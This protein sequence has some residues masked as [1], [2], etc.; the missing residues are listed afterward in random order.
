M[1]L[2][3]LLKIPPLLLPAGTVEQVGVGAS[4][5]IY[6]IMGGWLSHVICTWHEEDEFA[7]GAQLTQVGGWG[8]MG[9]TAR[10]LGE[11]R[12]VAIKHKWGRLLCFINLS[13]G[14]VAKSTVKPGV[15]LAVLAQKPANHAAALMLRLCSASTRLGRL[16]PP[17][18]RLLLCCVI[19]RLWATPS[20][21][22]RL[23]LHLSWIG[24]LCTED[25]DG[26]SK[27]VHI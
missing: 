11:S 4:G 6:A 8:G 5:A 2:V 9:L 22:W 3:T 14:S 25:D 20:S 15:G 7:K 26:A 27:C 10:K 17:C 1:L 12:I 13:G 21:E 19:G 16:L 18:R 23:P 24:E